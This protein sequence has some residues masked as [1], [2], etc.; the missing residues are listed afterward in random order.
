MGDGL[1]FCLTCNADKHP[2]TVFTADGLVERCPTCPNVFSR[3]GTEPPAPASPA[4]PVAAPSPPPPAPQAQPSDTLSLLDSMRAR[5][6]FC[7]DQ[8]AAR[9]GYIAEREMLKKMLAA[10]ENVTRPAEA[11][12]L[13]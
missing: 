3:M 12:P 9:D 10:A 8:I 6:A 13:N 7:E 5:L 11:K 2:V 4:A 1:T